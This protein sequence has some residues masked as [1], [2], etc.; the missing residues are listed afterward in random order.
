[1][2]LDREE[3]RIALSDF[4]LDREEYR[5]ALSDFGLE[6][7]E[8]R[9]EIEIPGLADAAMDMRLAYEDVCDAE[10]TIALLPQ[11]AR[12]TFE[13]G[14]PEFL[15]TELEDR[16]RDF[17]IIAVTA[18]ITAQ[19]AAVRAE[20][21][22]FEDLLAERTA[23]LKA[24][25]VAK[26]H[27]FRDAMIEAQTEL[28]NKLPDILE[29]SLLKQIDRIKE[30]VVRAQD[31]IIANLDNV[32]ID[33]A[34]VDHILERVKNRPSGDDPVRFFSREW[35]LDDI[36]RM[37]CD[38]YY[39]SERVALAMIIASQDMGIETEELRDLFEGLAPPG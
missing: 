32:Y 12:E 38:Y 2:G 19:I 14:Y 16:I 22:R 7:E 20:F 36:Y 39:R 15:R 33:T 18:A 30:Q 21:D 10:R 11:F 37:L 26:T 6:R 3:Y 35:S 5:I 34:A 1:F 13:A 25:I 4:G 8:Y 24:D 28:I 31:E 17:L 27:E 9:I 29:P 23:D